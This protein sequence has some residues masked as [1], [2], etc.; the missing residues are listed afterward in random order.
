MSVPYIGI[1]LG[2]VCGV[3]PEI[4]VK[5]LC[6]P[7][8]YQ[9]CRPVVIGDAKALEQAAYMLGKKVKILSPPWEVTTKKFGPGQVCLVPVSSLQ[10]K[11]LVYGHPTPTV[12]K[13]AVEYIKMAVAL[14]MDGKIQGMVTCP[15]NKAIINAA[16]IPFT[17]HTELLAKLT[18]T[19][20]FAMLLVGE[21]LKVALVT[22]HIAL[23]DV[24]RII[25]QEKILDLID[26]THHFLKEK[27]RFSQPRLAVAGLNPHAGEGGLMGK[28]E[29]EI[30]APAVKAAQT[31]G[32]EVKGPFPPDTVF[33][34][35]KEGYYDVVICMYHDQGLIPFKLL[36]FRDGVNVTMG[37]PIVRTSVDHGTAYDIAGKGIADEN[38]L[39]A[40]IRL[41]AEMVR[42]SQ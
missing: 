5:A 16:G 38:S 25:S 37:L 22:I 11:D 29:I 1:T 40:A 4:T 15:V 24:S 26:L 3:G 28:E 14:T 8:I 32:I 31:M 39:V 30:I 36:H 41:A 18:H 27:L 13:A 42:K 12:G 10:E 9:Y 20:R 33:Y 19:N 21:R 2:D 34:W 7:E 23:K 6:R 35:A 17:G